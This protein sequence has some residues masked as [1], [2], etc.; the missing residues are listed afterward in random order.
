MVDFSKQSEKGIGG[1]GGIL[2]HLSK[3][4]QFTD[5]LSVWQFSYYPPPPIIDSSSL[6]FL[7]DFGRSFYLFIY[8][9][10]YGKKPSKM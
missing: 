2:S 5:I 8:I 6:R 10:L 4:L 7:S 9:Y 3:E 1:V